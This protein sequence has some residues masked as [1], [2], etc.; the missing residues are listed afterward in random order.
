MLIAYLKQEIDF[1]EENIAFVDL[2]G[3]GKTQDI[4][5]EVLNEI[6][7]CNVYFFYI[8]NPLMEQKNRSINFVTEF[9][10]HIFI[11][12]NCLDEL[13]QVRLSVINMK[14]IK[15]YRLWK[16]VSRKLCLSGD[17]MNI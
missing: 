12:L 4:I 16:K 9:I 14:I 7:P 17:I 10:V 1:T 2:D 3:S 8:T 5:S 6:K 11:G 15:S 13:R